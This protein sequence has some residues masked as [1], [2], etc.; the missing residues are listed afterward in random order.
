MLTSSHTISK[1]ITFLAKHFIKIGCI[2]M[3]CRCNLF[4]M[5]LPNTMIYRH[6]KCLFILGVTILWSK[7]H[8]TLTDLCGFITHAR[9]LGLV[10]LSRPL[11]NQVLLRQ[12][13]QWGWLSTGWSCLWE[14]TE[15]FL[16]MYAV[17]SLIR[18][19]CTTV[20][21]RKLVGVIGN[22]WAFACNVITVLKQNKNRLYLWWKGSNRNLIFTFS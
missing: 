14:K 18:H 13:V 3:V 12:L 9:R 7:L 19:Y 22:W 4:D 1:Y 17:D 15:V 10:R 5:L 11:S 2:S 6:Y 16:I 21:E 8:V 20:T